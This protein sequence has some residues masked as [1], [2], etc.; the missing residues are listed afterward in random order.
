MGWGVCFQLDQK[1]CVVCADG[2]SWKSKDADYPYQWPSSRHAVLEYYEGDA[3]RELDMVRDE[4]PGTASAL[5]AACDEHFS[6]ALES[7]ERL[8]SAHKTKLHQETLNKLSE[9]L[10]E[11]TGKLSNARAQY[12][13]A[14]ASWEDCV[15]NPPKYKKTAKTRLEEI[16]REMYPLNLERTM[17]FWAH[18]VDLLTRRI[19]EYTKHLKMEKMFSTVASV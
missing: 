19:R 4:C 1:N 14:K 5:A 3:H 11:F 18:E 6:S 15:K 9:G 12:K 7:Y 16:D 13:E 17:E 10:G 2:C 8:S